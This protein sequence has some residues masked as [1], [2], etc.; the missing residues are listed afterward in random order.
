MRHPKS[1]ETRVRITDSTSD[2]AP[3]FLLRGSII[4]TPS[5]QDELH[6]S[7]LFPWPAR[8]GQKGQR[9]KGHPAAL[10]LA[11]KFTVLGVLL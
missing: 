2:S 11:P 10:L 7:A 8:F 1:L 4:R 5:S 3:V 9:C 6:A